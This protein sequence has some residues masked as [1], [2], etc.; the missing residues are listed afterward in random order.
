MTDK[1]ETVKHVETIESVDH[2]PFT[3]AR[4]LKLGIYRPGL[5]RRLITP[6]Q[7]LRFPG[8][9][10]VMLHYGGLL[11][12]IVTISSVAPLL[13]A[14]PPWL[15]GSNV[16]LIN[17]GG[18]IGAALGALYVYVTSDWYVKYKARRE[19][20]G[21]GEPEARLPLLFPGLVL[22][23]AGALVFGFSAQGR[24]PMGW[25]GMEFGTVSAPDVCQDCTLTRFWIGHDL[26]W[27]DASPIY[28]LQ[29][30]D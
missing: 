20:R 14:E 17:V 18:L 8:T 28:R 13:L 4:S 15:W 22:A 21:F 1:K 3:F 16:G 27:T 26:V 30:S 23:V 19:V 2:R 9:L 24:S 29:L 6:F 10:M 7:T 12:L 11:A 5:L 25:V